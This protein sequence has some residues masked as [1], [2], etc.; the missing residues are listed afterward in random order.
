M[1]KKMITGTTR[2]KHLF[3]DTNKH[4]KAEPIKVKQTSTSPHLAEIKNN[5]EEEKDDIETKV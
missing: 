5:I 3:V 4:A 1:M 2:E